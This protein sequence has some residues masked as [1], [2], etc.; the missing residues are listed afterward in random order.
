MRQKPKVCRL[1]RGARCKV[2]ILY[3]FSLSLLSPPEIYFS[4][5]EVETREVILEKGFETRDQ[6]FRDTTLSFPR[7][8]GDSAD[9]LGSYRG[10]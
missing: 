9:R 5:N 1:Q 8:D 2:K 4:R 6:M 10:S 7:L 3:V